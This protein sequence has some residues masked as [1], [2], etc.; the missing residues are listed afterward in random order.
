MLHRG[1]DSSSTGGRGEALVGFGLLQLGR[2]QASEPPSPAPY[3]PFGLLQLLSCLCRFSP[4]PG[5]HFSDCASTRWVRWTLKAIPSDLKGLFTGA[6]QP[7]SQSSW[8]P[9]AIVWIRNF[10]LNQQ[11]HNQTSCH[12]CGCLSSSMFLTKI[13]IL[14][15]SNVTFSSWDAV[16]RFSTRRLLLFTFGKRSAQRWAQRANLVRQRWRIF[17]QVNWQEAEREKRSEIRMK[18]PSASIGRSIFNDTYR[19]S[20]WNGRHCES[21]R[22]WSLFHIQPFLHKWTR[23]WDLLQSYENNIWKRS[24]LVCQTLA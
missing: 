5:F 8:E 18:S 10:S 14:E 4:P 16:S 13:T 21:K 9:T 24:T 17:C 3:Q 2:D 23:G 22:I 6:H 19:E 12:Y 11:S 15:W 1:L 20:S 7:K